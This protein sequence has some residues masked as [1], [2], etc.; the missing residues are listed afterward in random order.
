MRDI[1]IFLIG[2]LG[3]AGL[4]RAWFATQ[5]PI[6]FFKLLRHVGWGANKEW[7]PKET[8]QFWLRHECE[9][10]WSLNLHPL[11]GELLCCPICL[12]Y[13][14]SWW[15]AVVMSIFGAPLWILAAWLAWPELINLLPGH[16]G[17]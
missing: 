10:W 1:N 2:F 9:S 4:H 3:V 13:H 17:K 15:A 8:Y 6:H 7:P 12:S 16:Q 5:L 11:V 14:L